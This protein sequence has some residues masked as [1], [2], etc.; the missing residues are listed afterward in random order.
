MKKIIVL[1]IFSIFLNSC[2]NNEIWLDI[3]NNI[4]DRIEEEV[5]KN[6]NLEEKANTQIIEK[7]YNIQKAKKLIMKNNNIFVNEDW[8]K[9]I[10]L[11]TKATWYRECNWNNKWKLIWAYV[12]KNWWPSWLVSYNILNNE[13]KYWIV[14][15]YFNSCEGIWFRTLYSIN[16]NNNLS[17][18]S[19]LIDINAFDFELSEFLKIDWNYIYIKIDANNVTNNKNIEERWMYF[20][21]DIIKE[22]YKKQWNIWIKKFDLLKIIPDTLSNNHN[23]KKKL[24]NNLIKTWKYNHNNLIKKWYNLNK[25]SGINE[26]YK[27]VGTLPSMEYWKWFTTWKTI[28]IKWNKILD[29]EIN[30]WWW[31]N[32]IVNNPKNI[33]IIDLSKYNYPIQPIFNKNK[34]GSKIIVDSELNNIKLINKEK[35]I[36]NT[37]WKK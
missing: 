28:Y 36:E 16:L 11:T 37:L 4:D 34:S 9:D 1:I 26:Y 5:K 14:E 35:W 2:S 31:Q 10:I 23:I 3:K 15:K 22:W 12:P 17:Q 32:L 24:N 6:N 21:W 8:K 7:K 30:N 20:S 25:L 29:F 13:W 33:S 19:E 18:D 27:E